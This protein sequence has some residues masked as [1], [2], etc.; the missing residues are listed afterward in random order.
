MSLARLLAICLISNLFAACTSVP[1]QQFTSFNTATVEFA[2]KSELTYKRLQA[3]SSA[4]AVLDAPDT[5]LTADS[6][7]AEKDLAGYVN[8]MTARLDVIE[9]Y[10]KALECLAS[11]DPTADIESAA[12]DLS[13]SANSLGKVTNHISPEAANEVGALADLIGRWAT[14]NDRKKGLEEAMQKAQPALVAF[15]REIDE[16]SGELRKML[17]LIRDNYLLHA[18]KMRPPY[19]TWSRAVFDSSVASRL[20]EYNDIGEALT[21]MNAAAKQLPAANSNLLQSVQQGA[22][23]RAGLT[24]FARQVRQIRTFYRGLPT[25]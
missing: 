3:I 7:Q 17:V 18:N 24:N 14:Y 2:E 9:K 4:S 10:A 6:F 19:Q 21:A 16:D 20:T 15:A 5:A 25:T 1:T 13:S 11:T 8:A 22:V 12:T 23:S